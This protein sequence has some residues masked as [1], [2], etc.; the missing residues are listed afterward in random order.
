MKGS[1]T[2][3]GNGLVWGILG[4][5]PPI[6]FGELCKKSGIFMGIFMGSSWQPWPWLKENAL[7]NRGI[8]VVL[9]IFRTSPEQKPDSL[10]SGKFP[11]LWQSEYHLSSSL[12]NAHPLV[13]SRTLQ[14]KPYF[15]AL[16]AGATFCGNSALQRSSCS[17]LPPC[18][19][20][21]F[22]GNPPPRRNPGLKRK[23]LLKNEF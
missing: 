1:T 3:F 9:C 4:E 22:A 16:S 17:L 20:K 23:I 12:Q 14:E 13:G 11:A 8:H 15:V 18:W 19:S 7:N 21:C 10:R 5:F 6:F 2:L